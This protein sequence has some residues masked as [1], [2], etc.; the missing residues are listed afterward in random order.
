MQVDVDLKMI[1]LS[2][3]IDKKCEKKSGEK[4]DK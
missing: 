2:E 1:N 4:S 3:K